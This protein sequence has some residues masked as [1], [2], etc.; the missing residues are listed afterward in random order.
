MSQF[1]QSNELEFLSALS[2]FD[3]TVSFDHFDVGSHLEFE[4][5]LELENK[6]EQTDRARQAIDDCR[7]EGAVIIYPGHPFYPH[8][9][10]ELEKPPLFLSLI[11]TPSWLDHHCM[12]VVGSRDISNDV[13]DWMR[14]H[15][16]RFLEKVKGVAIVSGGARGVDQTAHLISIR[17]QRPTVAF[18]PS[19]ILR[20]YPSQIMEWRE[21][22][23]NAGGGLI[24][25]YAPRQEIRKHHFEGRNHLIACLS[26]WLF[27]AQAKRRSGSIMTARLARDLGREIA[28]LPF[29]PSANEG[30]GTLD[31]LMEDTQMIRDA[32]DLMA[33]FYRKAHALKTRLTPSPSNNENCND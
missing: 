20:P 32:E 25:P 31:L 2:L 21:N 33:F 17:K 28:A 13:G 30:S 12:A 6:S 3:S 7:N 22:I 1:H 8:V 26:P 29:F 9:F 18:L 14:L 23:L 10:S 16:A 19:G 24:S 11:G 4:L 15:F 27:V 5:E